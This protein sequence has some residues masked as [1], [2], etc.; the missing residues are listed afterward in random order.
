MVMIPPA[1]AVV[2]GA[3]PEATVRAARALGGVAPAP[4]RAEKA[5]ETLLGQRLTEAVIHQVSL[6]ATAVP[7]GSSRSTDELLC[8]AAAVE[9][10]SEHPVAK[11]IVR[12]SRAMAEDEKGF[13]SHWPQAPAT[14]LGQ[15]SAWILLARRCAA[16][17]RWNSSIRAPTTSDSSDSTG[18]DSRDA[19][20]RIGC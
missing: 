20:K 9:Q 14:E 5:E 11:A 17:G 15:P 10:Y 18:R 7:D 8:L 6:A 2:S 3:P 1:M 19:A 13:L 16:I 12:A 4:W